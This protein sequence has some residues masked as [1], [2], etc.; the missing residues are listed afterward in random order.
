MVKDADLMD[1]YIKYKE[2]LAELGKKKNELAVL[3]TL[4]AST[5]TR[6]IKYLQANPHKDKKNKLAKEIKELRKQLME[7]IPNI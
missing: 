2:R 6:Y 5:S 1:D 3:V 4:H 7:L